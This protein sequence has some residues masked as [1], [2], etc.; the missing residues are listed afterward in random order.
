MAFESPLLFLWL[1]VTFSPITLHPRSLVLNNLKA[2]VLSM[3][4]FQASFCKVTFPA[5]QL[6]YSIAA[7]LTISLSLS[8]LR[9][10]VSSLSEPFRDPQDPK[11]PFFFPIPKTTKSRLRFH[12]LSWDYSLKQEAGQ[13]PPNAQIYGQTP[14]AMWANRTSFDH[15]KQWISHVRDKLLSPEFE[16]K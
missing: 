16:V 10:I 9:Q 14:C 6:S 13:S 11:I 2:S 5:L 3:S 7:C 4:L 12:Y 8:G 15:E 1:R